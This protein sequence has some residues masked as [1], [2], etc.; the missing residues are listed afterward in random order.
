MVRTRGAKAGGTGEVLM[1]GCKNARGVA[2]AQGK[3][4]WLLSY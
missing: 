3:D 1:P 4:Y 2:V